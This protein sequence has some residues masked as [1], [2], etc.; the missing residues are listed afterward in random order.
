MSKIEEIKEM[1]HNTFEILCMSESLEIIEDFIKQFQPVLDI[2]YDDC[3]YLE[4]VTVKRKDIELFHLFVKY[5]AIVPPYLKEFTDN[6]IKQIADKHKNNI[7][8]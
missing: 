6:L 7:E 2:N 8:I 1:I 4:I 5:G 3:W